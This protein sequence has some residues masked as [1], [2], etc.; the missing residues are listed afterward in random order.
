MQ[1]AT[2]TV[3][4]NDGHEI[5]QLGLGV[6]QVREAAECDRAVREALDA[7]YR[8]ID[9][10]AAYR[11]EAAVGKAIAGSGIDREKIYVTTKVFIQGLGREAT[12]QACEGSLKELGT[13]Y[14]DLYLIHWPVREKVAEAWET[15]QDLRAE[16]KIR[17][18]GVSNFMVRRFEEQFFKHTDVIPAV[19]QIELHPF[20]TCTE[21][22]QYCRDKGIQVEGYS[23]LA[24]AQRM[25]NATLKQVAD[26]HGKSVA[27][28]MIRW[29]LQHGWVVIPKSS[30]P[31]RIKSN[32]AVFDFEISA[33]DM[34]R[35]DGLNEDFIT[36]DWRPEE[37]WF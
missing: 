36:I 19:N 18:I 20:N 12:R 32:A 25:D 37:D 29:Q 34:T 23:P 30:R 3:K 31:D 14:V 6:F 15:M 7:G 24:R 10:A 33:G 13:D 5:P 1:D 2:T 26:A 28:V 27:Q 4:L 9:T 22:V 8:H 21:L 35:I 17:S 11:N 16:G